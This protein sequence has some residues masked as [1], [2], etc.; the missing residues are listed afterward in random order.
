MASPFSRPIEYAPYVQ[1]VDK[2]LFAKAVTYKQGKFDLNRSKLQAQLDAAAQIP[3]DKKEDREYFN[4]RMTALVNTVNLHGAGDISSDTRADYLSGYIAEAADDNV[5]TGYA[6]TMAKR[7]YDAEWAKISE[8]D[9]SKFSQENYEYGLQNYYKWLNDGQIGSSV[10]KY[11]DPR[12]GKG[13]G[14]AT[15]FINVDE[16]IREKLAEIDPTIS[17]TLSPFG[18]GIQYFDEKREVITDEQ[19][20]ND[21]NLTLSGDPNLRNQLQINTWSKFGNAS[22]EQLTELIQQRNQS[23][24]ENIDKNINSLQLHMAE[25]PQAQEAQLQESINAL[26]DRKKSLEQAS[27]LEAIAPRLADANARIQTEYSLYTEDL[28]GGYI[29]RYAKDQ[30]VSR[31]QFTD[32]KAKAL[33]DSQ[34]RMREARAKAALDRQN[35]MSAAQR[36]LLQDMLYANAAGDIAKADAAAVMLNNLYGGTGLTR[37]VTNSAGEVIGQRQ[38]TTDELI[39]EQTLTTVQSYD[40]PLD[41]EAEPGRQL[42]DNINNSAQAIAVLRQD[43]S[44]LTNYDMELTETW[45]SEQYFEKAKDMTIP[46]DQRDLL[47]QAGNA[48]QSQESNLS[49]MSSLNE[50][51]T[52]SIMTVLDKEGV[53]KYEQSGLWDAAGQKIVRQDDGTLIFRDFLSS[54]GSKSETAAIYKKERERRR[55]NANEWARENIGDN[56]VV[57]AIADF[58]SWTYFA[59]GDTLGFL[60]GQ[61]GERI[62]NLATQGNFRYENSFRENVVDNVIKSDERIDLLDEYITDNYGGQVLEV[63]GKKVLAEDLV[64]KARLRE[65][66]DEYEKLDRSAVGAF[67]DLGPSSIILENEAD[68]VE[69]LIRDLNAEYALEVPG[70]E[71]PV[72]A[73]GNYTEDPSKIVGYSNKYIDLNGFMTEEYLNN[74]NIMAEDLG[75]QMPQLKTM[76]L[77]TPA[78]ARYVRDLM[79]SQ[80]QLPEDL[81][82]ELRAI[83]SSE[84]EF[85]K[86]LNAERKEDEPSYLFE[87]TDIGASIDQVKLKVSVDGEEE[88]TVPANLRPNTGLY[89]VAQDAMIAQTQRANI[90]LRKIGNFSLAKDKGLAGGDPVYN[91]P[92]VPAYAQI[93]DYKLTVDIAN[94]YTAD[95]SVRERQ[96]GF[97]GYQKMTATEVKI[98]DANTNALLSTVNTVGGQPVTSYTVSSYNNDEILRNY[99]NDY[100]VQFSSN[101]FNDFGEAI[102]EEFETNQ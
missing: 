57:G 66:N 20:I 17:F 36:G 33:F 15:P 76:S 61:T 7:N 28:F 67:F 77:N 37:N 18:N 21:I 32:Q 101:F 42:I 44:S 48:K 58:A 98:F 11:F 41:A 82:D 70:A 13:V 73:D 34:L 25:V 12:V 71:Y 85:V 90:N 56:A 30:V 54:G 69:S 5:A 22:T 80:D 60:W 100:A 65:I 39:Q 83:M 88:Y 102:V 19:I 59:G 4:E 46:G 63:E 8:D 86:Y 96:G 89:D 38:A 1:Q 53:V 87:V 35:T 51:V 55:E 72:D 9:P 92:V 31:T 50:E 79:I 14:R 62:T 75:L 93:G 64:E 16:K 40:Q 84:K 97:P 6:S 74:A 45:T 78:G 29:E 26:K 10:D 81:P 91:Y 3:L 95:A 99:D 43:L 47:M 24:I 68:D 23:K 27:S 49:L 94:E 52:R 2:E